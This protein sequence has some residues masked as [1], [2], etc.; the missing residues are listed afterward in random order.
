LTVFLASL[1][2]SASICAGFE[3]I[4]VV[5][6]DEQHHPVR[7]ATVWVVPCDQYGAF[8]SS[9]KSLQTNE[10]GRVKI[11]VNPLVTG[12]WECTHFVLWAVKGD[13]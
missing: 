5:V 2:L 7:G 13:F 6:E 1:F 11:K 8:L 12:E 9:P 3:E 4:H 10:T